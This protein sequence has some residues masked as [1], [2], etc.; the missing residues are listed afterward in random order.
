MGMKFTMDRWHWTINV[1][2]LYLCL[3][4][5]V[6]VALTDTNSEQVLLRNSKSVKFKESLHPMFTQNSFQAAHRHTSTHGRQKIHKP[7]IMAHTGA[8][9]D[10]KELDVNSEQVL[11]YHD[12]LS[13]FLYN[14]K[15]NR[16]Q[17]HFKH[18]N[19]Y[20]P[21]MKTQLRQHF[22][23]I[24]DR[25]RPSSKD[26][27]SNADSRYFSKKDKISHF[28]GDTELERPKKSISPANSKWHEIKLVHTENISSSISQPANEFEDESSLVKRHSSSGQGFKLQLWKSRHLVNEAVRESN[29]VGRTTSDHNLAGQPGQGYYIEVSIGSPPQQLNVLVDT[30]SSNFAVAAAPHPDISK[31]FD[32]LSSSTYQEN[33]TEVYVPYTQGHWRGPLGNDIIKFPSMPNITARANLALI[34]NSN[35]FFINDSNWQGILGLAYADIA[36]PDASV[37]P[38]FDSL[39]L[40]N[41]ASIQNLFSLQLCS[42]IESKDTEEKGMGGTLIIGGVDDGLYRGEFYWAPMHREWY[43]EVVITDVMVNNASLGMACVEYNT[44]KTIVD[45]GT[46]N[47]RLPTKVYHQLVKVI[48][49][50]LKPIDP[51]PPPDFWTGQKM[52]CWSD[53]QVPWSSFPVI[54]LALANS[55]D[56]SIVLTI[57][58]QMYLRAV[59]NLPGD[60][61]YKFS[62]APSNT[63]SVLGAVV[64]EGYYIVFDRG[65]KSVGFAE[66][67][68]NPRTK[69]IPPS[70]VHG[71]VSTANTQQCQYVKPEAGTPPMVIVAYV[72]AGISGICILPLLILILQWKIQQCRKQKQ[73]VTD[74]QSLMAA[75]D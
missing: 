1:V 59:D 48:S 64:L 46:T 31:Y 10:R 9:V 6:V 72:M 7:T 68:C 37:Q 75:E 51:L 49:K 36:R 53:D 20:G 58:P 19:S 13:L 47:L 45:S 41:T 62:V 35:K 65:N 3:L 11:Q 56:S 70:K 39:I 25:T 40:Q 2:S 29:V 17:I 73:T 27:Q 69:E 67:T 66:T 38:F 26:I 43:Y 74:I 52:L 42:T 54:S 14:Q 34:T 5:T 33:G 16:H 44:D 63:G 15:H 60:G 61:C 21:L 30:G 24:G 18:K 50:Q 23:A 71:P 57:S 22:E 55:Q 8:D 12:S 4:Y 32:K 28:H